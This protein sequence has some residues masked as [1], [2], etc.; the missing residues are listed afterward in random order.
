MASKGCQWFCYV[1]KIFDELTVVNSNSQECSYLF[2]ILGGFISLI[3]AV[4][5]GCGFDA[6]SA[7]DMTKILD[8]LGKELTLTQFH[9]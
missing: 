3:A 4:L 6:S 8:F 7:E 1:G 9:S 2:S 5:E